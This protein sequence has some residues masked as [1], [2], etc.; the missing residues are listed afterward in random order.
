MVAPQPVGS[1][2][3]QGLSNFMKKWCLIIMS[4]PDDEEKVDVSLGLV[5]LAKSHPQAIVSDTKTLG[6]IAHA[7]LSWDP[8][9]ANSLNTDLIKIFQLYFQGVAQSMTPQKWK[10]LQMSW[11]G[12]AANE[13]R[14]RLQL[15]IDSAQDVDIIFAVKY[16]NVED[17]KKILDTNQEKDLIVLVNDSNGDNALDT[18]RKQRSNSYGEK[19]TWNEIIELLIDSLPDEKFKVLEIEKEEAALEE[20][21]RQRLG[22][23]ENNPWSIKKEAKLRE[24]ERRQQLGFN[25]NNPWSI[26]KEIELKL[27]TACQTGNINALNKL[28]ENNKDININQP[29]QN[30]STSLF[31]ACKQG[32]L[33]IVKRLLLV[34]G[35][36]IQP[37]KNEESILLK[38]GDQVEAMCDEW[39]QYYNGTITN[40]NSDGTYNITFDD[41]EQKTNVTK[42]QLKQFSLK[43]ND[44]VE[45]TCD[46]WK[47]VYYKGKIT[48][49]NSTGTYNITFDDGERKYGV[50]KNK[51]KVVH[52]IPIEIAKENGHDAIVVLLTEY[53][54]TK[55]KH[56][57]ENE[58]KKNEKK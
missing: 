55:E 25:E 48:N 17:V 40:L 19:E 4:M 42:N 58:K 51:I 26:E 49:V 47:N 36:E 39:K 50:E 54:N 45:A 24:E 12:G 34:Q 15:F 43:I 41:G 3:G 56:D 20:E 35:I 8:D 27:F 38:Q 11:G 13:L 30:G 37:P 33:E 53:D 2:L 23:N 9:I 16:G 32:H 14:E 10:Q 28:L 57:D 7:L 31:T 29:Q 46:E 21:R 22:F 44:Q 52:L 6:F 1:A 5:K 18:A